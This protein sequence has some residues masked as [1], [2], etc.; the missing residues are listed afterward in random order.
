MAMET[1]SKPWEGDQSGWSLIEDRPFLQTLVKLLERWLVLTKVN[2]EGILSIKTMRCRDGSLMQKSRVVQY[3]AQCLLSGIGSTIVG[4][5][6]ELYVPAA[7][8]TQLSFLDNLSSALLIPPLHFH[9]HHPPL[10]L[11]SST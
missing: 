4:S 3:A 10:S 6:A 7:R 9:H 11:P 5:V 1:F 2:M 8:L